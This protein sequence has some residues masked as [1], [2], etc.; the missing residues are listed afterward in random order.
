MRQAAAGSLDLII[1][2]STDPI[3]PGEILFSEEF[4]AACQRALDDGG[5]MIQQS[6]SPLLHMDLIERMYCNMRGAGFDYRRSLFFPLCVYPSGWWSA[7]LARKGQPIDGFRE[8]AVTERP[9]T[10]RYYN[11]AI[12]QAAFAAPSFFAPER[13][14]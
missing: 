7:T 5:I 6:E 14:N 2:D 1:V 12:H 8:Q 11:A 13:D 10:T 3:G 9:F 4:Y